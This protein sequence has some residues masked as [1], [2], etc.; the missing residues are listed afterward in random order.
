MVER[1]CDRWDAQ[2]AGCAHYVYHGPDALVILQREVAQHAGLRAH[3]LDKALGTHLSVSVCP[4]HMQHDY[5]VV[6]ADE[7]EDAGYVAQLSQTALRHL[8]PKAAR[9]DKLS[10]VHAEADVQRAGQLPDLP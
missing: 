9:L 7:V 2:R 8:R 3:H 5:G 10:G 1:V 4:A 6:A